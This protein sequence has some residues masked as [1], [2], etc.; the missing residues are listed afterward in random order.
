MVALSDPRCE[1]G[2]LTEHVIVNTANPPN[3][4]PL[5]PGKQGDEEASA[6]SPP[7]VPEPIYH[8]IHPSFPRPSFKLENRYIDQPRS[9]R[10]VVIGAG[11]AGITA[12]IL[13]PRKV[14]GIDLQ[15]YEKNDEVVSSCAMVNTGPHVLSEQGRSLARE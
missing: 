15:I 1:S 5:I 6:K 3:N 2:A 9:L 4:I 14:P 7:E 13:L 8:G 11:L 10:V 12:G